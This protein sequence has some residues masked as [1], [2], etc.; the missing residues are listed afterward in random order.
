VGTRAR[1]RDDETCDDDDAN[2]DD[3]STRGV[4]ERARAK[5]GGGRGVIVIGRVGFGVGVEVA[6][7]R[8]G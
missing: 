5:R 4:L 3:G 8:E 6:G 7:R 2:D 1:A